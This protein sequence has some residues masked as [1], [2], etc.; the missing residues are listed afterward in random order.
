M[1]W[2][3]QAM[4]VIIIGIVIGLAFKFWYIVIVL[5]WLGWVIYNI[6]TK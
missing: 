4:W 1:G 5:V 6:K 3:E 2:I